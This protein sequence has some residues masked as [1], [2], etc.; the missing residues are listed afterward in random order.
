[1]KT[2]T[3]DKISVFLA[4]VI[5][6]GLLVFLG[7]MGCIGGLG[8]IPTHLQICLN[9]GLTVMII[10]QVSIFQFKNFFNKF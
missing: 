9:F 4:E 2:S 7:C 3:L 1:M 8:G 6:T 5:G 10:I